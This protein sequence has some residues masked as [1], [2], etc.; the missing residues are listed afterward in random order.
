ML[1]LRARSTISTLPKIRTGAF[2]GML[3][4]AGTRSARLSMAFEPRHFGSLAVDRDAVR[5]LQLASTFVT[6]ASLR[7]CVVRGHGDGRRT[8]RMFDE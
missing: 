3:A 5:S 8:S 1:T 2:R 6:A 7:R 4:S